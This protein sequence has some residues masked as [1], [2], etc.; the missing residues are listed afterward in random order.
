[1]IMAPAVVTINIIGRQGLLG[2]LA[3]AEWRC[4]HT[5]A[6]R[7]GGRVSVSCDGRRCVVPLDL[8]AVVARGLGNTPSVQLLRCA[9][10]ARQKTCRERQQGED[11]AGRFVV[12]AEEL[13]ADDGSE[14]TV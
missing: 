12:M 7:D 13:G 2:W 11:V 14:R 8:P 4:P 10:R 1:M 3:C 6:L 9:A 5:Q